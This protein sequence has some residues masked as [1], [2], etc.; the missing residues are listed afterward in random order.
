MRLFFLFSISVLFTCKTF[1]QDTVPTK[2]TVREVLAFAEVMPHFPGGEGEF[3]KYLQ[4]NIHYPDTARKY[5]RE[6]T[7]YIYFVVKHDG[8]ISDVRSMKGVSGAPELAEEAIHVIR[9]MPD[10]EPGK[11]NGRAVNVGMTI[12]IRFSLN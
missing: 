2:D 10:W 7:V 11:M 5:G 8:S 12:P 4:A 3:Q 9:A 6:G 1:A